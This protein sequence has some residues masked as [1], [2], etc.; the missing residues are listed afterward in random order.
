MCQTLQSVITPF[1]MRK[2]NNHNKSYE[3]KLKFIATLTSKLLYYSCDICNKFQ[4]ALIFYDFN[5]DLLHGAFQQG[6]QRTQ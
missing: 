6:T 2:V 3:Y 4:S 5:N 1:S